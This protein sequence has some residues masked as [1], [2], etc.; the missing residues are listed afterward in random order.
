VLRP[1]GVM[2]F[3]EPLD[4]NPVGMLVRMATPEARTEDET[5]LKLSHLDLFRERFETTFY[6]QQFVSVPAGVF[7]RFAMKNADNPVMRSAFNIDKALSRTPGLRFLFRKLV[8]VG[9]KRPS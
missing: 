3:N 8:I 6:P 1:G 5:P 9:V 7:S 2:I 4:V